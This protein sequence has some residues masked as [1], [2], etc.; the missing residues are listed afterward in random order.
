MT[1]SALALPSSTTSK[2]SSSAACR[3][4]ASPTMRT[5]APRSAWAATYATAA[6]ALVRISCGVTSIA[7]RRSRSATSSGL[8]VELLVTSRN[9]S[10]RRRASDR[11]PAAP[12]IGSLPVYTTPSRSISRPC[13]AAQSELMPLVEQEAQATA[14]VVQ[15]L[16][17]FLGRD[18]QAQRSDRCFDLAIRVDEALLGGGE[19]RTGGLL[20]Q[21]CRPTAQFFVGRLHVDHHVRVHLAQPDHQRRA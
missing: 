20:D 1:Q 21:P 7:I 5:R 19:P 18:A 10:P 12:G 6:W 13:S 4:P 11:N 16:A 8:V 2:P 3:R 9:F 14:D 17:R 15:A